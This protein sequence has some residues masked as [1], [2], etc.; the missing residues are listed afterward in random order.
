M[1]APNT[2]EEIAL[3]LGDAATGMD[4]PAFR[5]VR[6]M[7]YF[8]LAEARA[9]AEPRLRP[10]SETPEPGS[11]VI[12]LDKQTGEFSS[13]RRWP[14]HDYVPSRYAGWILLERAKPKTLAEKARDI[15]SERYA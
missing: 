13:A 2:M 15:L 1:S 5:R 14:P 8:W 7:I 10:V 12:M 6:E 3:A 9:N 4:G 11:V